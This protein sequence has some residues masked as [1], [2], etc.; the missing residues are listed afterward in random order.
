MLQTYTPIAQPPIFTILVGIT[1]NPREGH[2]LQ[3]AL[4][5]NDKNRYGANV[6]I[7]PETIRQEVTACA[8]KII[9]RFRCDGGTTSFKIKNG[10]TDF[11]GFYT[12]PEKCDL[13]DTPLL[14]DLVTSLWHFLADEQLAHKATETALTA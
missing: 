4:R 10:L 6:L 3:L 8:Q 5:V 1:V 2:F 14:T 11:V 9:T 12:E 7:E 13:C